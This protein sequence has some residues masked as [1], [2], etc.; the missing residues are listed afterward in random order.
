MDSASFPSWCLTPRQLCDIELILN[1]GFF[2][3]KGFLTQ[4]DYES[5][6]MHMQLS[7]VTVWPIPI[8]LDVTPE[9]AQSI[10]P[11]QKIRLTDPE[12]NPIAWM[13][14]SDRW[15]PDKRLEAERIFGTQDETHPGVFYLNRVAHDYYLGGEIEGIRRP[16]HYD[17]VHWRRDPAELKQQFQQ[18]GWQRIIAFQTRNPMHRAHYELTRWA[19]QQSEANLLIHPVVGLSKPG[20]VD[21][22]TRV[23]C[24]QKVLP[25][26]SEHT[27]LLNLLPLAMRMAGPREALWHAIIRKNYGCT[28]FI[29]GRD[30]AGPGDNAQ[31]MPFYDPY[32]AH[33]LLRYYEGKIGIHI[34][35]LQE[36]V[37]AKERA[38]YLPLDHTSS[39]DTIL[40]V[41]GTELRR[42]LQT[43]SE[44]P[45]WFS[46]PEV[47]NELRWWY[48]PRYR[49]GFTVF[50]TGLSGAGKSTLAL[51]LM[52][53]LMEVDTRV[54]TLLDGDRERR[55]LSTELGFSQQHRDWHV[56]RMSFVAEKITKS[57]GIAI[58]AQIA[59]YE[60][61][62]AYAREHI[63]A[64]GGFL[65]VYVATPLSVCEQRDAKGLYAKARTGVIS[66]FT[67]ITDPY[68][69]PVN[70]EVVVD[71]SVLTTE[72]A[73]DVILQKLSQLG[74]WLP[75]LNDQ[76]SPSFYSQR[77]TED[78]LVP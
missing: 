46:Y 67:G 74:Y 36:M 19:M 38:R 17:F 68:E 24:Y 10:H 42:R 8:T 47:V 39:R 13:Q 65:E 32:A 9:F 49:Q 50:L 30:H 5:V 77:V 60:M 73:V 59:P 20:D 33:D 22:F 16:K 63:S 40:T 34:V 57:K 6:L 23:R 54:V 69:I 21:Y 52:A 26:Y 61:S 64:V 4:A 28:H 25:Y 11:L 29:V 12:G 18:L 7:E 78:M 58:C 70:P 14:V 75:S 62:R 76:A 3:L 71:M 27:V 37:Y 31:G 1:G 48:P 35:A 43:G 55:H 56:K 41:S 53:R 51:A 45:D 44:I 66:A 2:P 72:Q 15:Q